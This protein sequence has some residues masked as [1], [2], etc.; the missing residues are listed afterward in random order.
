[1]LGKLAGAAGGLRSGPANNHRWRKAL[2][3]VAARPDRL[4]RYVFVLEL[5]VFVRR[6]CSVAGVKDTHVALLCRVEGWRSLPFADGNGWSVS[7]LSTWCG[8]R[9]TMNGHLKF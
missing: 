4:S 2:Q 5:G 7:T 1:M 3:L 9:G 6:A 8:Q